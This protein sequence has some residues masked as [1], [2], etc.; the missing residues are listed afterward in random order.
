MSLIRKKVT[1]KLVAANRGNSQKST[2][3][4]T[5]IGKGHSS[6]NAGKHLV[7]TTA[8]PTGMKKLGEDPAEFKRL[9]EG[10]R[11]TFQPQDDFESMLVEEMA[12]NRW[13]RQR[14]MRAENAILVSRRL[15]LKR[16]REWTAHMAR[17]EMHRACGAP[18]TSDQGLVNTAD[19]PEKFAS[20]LSIL[21]SVLDGY[22][23]DGFT[24][25]RHEPFG[26]IYG[27]RAS[28]RGNE[29]VLSY[30]LYKLCTED[31]G[32]SAED[33]AYAQ[34]LL[35]LALKDEIRYFEKEFELYRAREIDVTD[36][37]KD[38]RLLA[39]REGVHKI[40][41]YEAHLERQFER[42]LRQLVAWRRAK[43]ETVW[44]VPAS[45]GS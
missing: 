30:N 42:K 11:R 39:P 5:L 17:R 33:H 36:E 24:S 13:R 29:L 22:S 44:S 7:H 6:R 32:K 16:E 45:G 35:A 31:P 20:I 25:I 4:K 28:G 37:M 43:E 1:P 3:P 26:A 10:L 9:R 12:E 14:L 18:E 8:L 34:E 23:S 21:R 19:C 2:G 27:A 41:R 40:S 15:D 38:T